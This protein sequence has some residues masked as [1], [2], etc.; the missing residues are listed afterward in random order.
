MEEDGIK[1]T[2][3]TKAFKVK[4]GTTVK[5]HALLTSYELVSIDANTLQS[6]D[7]KVMVIDEAHRLKNSQSKVGLVGMCSS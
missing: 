6:I 2:K 7:W 5:F 4:T 1:H 3:G